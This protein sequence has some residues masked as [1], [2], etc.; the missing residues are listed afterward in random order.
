MVQGKPNKLICREL[1]LAESTVKVHITAILK[2]LKVATVP[3]R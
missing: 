3:R 2:T 1:G